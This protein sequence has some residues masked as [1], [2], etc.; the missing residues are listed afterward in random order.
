[1]R[2]A[3][4]LLLVLCCGIADAR[5]LAP[6]RPAPALDATLVD[7][8]TWSLSA[9]RGKVVIVNFWATWCGPCRAEMPALDAFQRAHRDEGLEVVGISLD[10]RAD[11]EQVRAATQG[12]AYPIALIEDTKANGYGR[13]WRV[14][15]TFVVDRDGTLRRDG[16]KSTP[17]VDA[18]MLEREVAPLLRQP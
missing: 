1:M 12:I 18:G 3:P 13:I 15:V 9:Q 2:P 10:D 6:G 17:T 11:L 4:F 5:G 16:F 8:R 7:G 14:P